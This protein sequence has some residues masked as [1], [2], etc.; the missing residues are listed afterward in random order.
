M[1]ALWLSA[2]LHL[3]IGWRIA[4]E[5]PGPVAPWA[6]SAVLLASAILIPLAFF[7]R[8]SRDR[9][10]ADRYSWAGMLALGLFSTLLVLHAAAR[11][12]AAAGVAVRPARRCRNSRRWRC[13]CWRR[14]SWRS[15]SVN[16]RRTARVR[17]VD[18]PVAGL[19]AALHGFTIAQISD[20]HVG[21][22]IKRAYLQAI[23]DAVNAL[24]PTRSR[25]PATWSTAACRTCAPHVAPLAAAALAPR[26]LLRHRQPRVLQRRRR[27][28][29]RAAA[30]GRAGA[31]ER[32]RG[33]A[34]TTAPA[35]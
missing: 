18:V 31:D 2:L 12:R 19:P 23:V 3:Y 16:A 15:A 22:T 30:P 6:F 4:P 17:D 9:A 14:C 26:H 21:P 13:R 7:G 32:A 25:S 33:A 27:M 35:W 28:D 5:L 11:R 1:F 20:I 8:R 29:R 24:R 10:K 34:T